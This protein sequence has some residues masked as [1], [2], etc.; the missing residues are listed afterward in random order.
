M[1]GFLNLKTLT[2]KI[3]TCA[4]LNNLSPPSEGFLL[5]AYLE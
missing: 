1:D 2:L 5:R 3:V 4:L